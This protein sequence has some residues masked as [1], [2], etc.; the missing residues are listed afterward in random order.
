[1]EQNIDNNEIYSN[2]NIGNIN[3]YKNVPVVA[4]RD[5]VVF[6]GTTVYFEVGREATVKAVNEAMH[7]KQYIFAVAQ[8]DPKVEHPKQNDLFEI[9]T[10]AQ[11]KQL[12]TMP[13]NVVRVIIV[14]QEKMKLGS[15]V[16]EDGYYKADLE[17]VEESRQ[18]SYDIETIALIRGLKDLFSVYVNERGRINK[19][20]VDEIMDCTDLDSL[21]NQ[22]ATGMQVN[23]QFKQKILAE[24][25]IYQRHEDIASKYKTFFL[26]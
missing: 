21:I 23:Y 7:G 25:D 14:G 17:K 6:P 22:I 10:L 9:G 24:T 12:V 19:N 8:K 15:L 4:L 20:V 1:M 5:V 2:N 26:I 3:E 13:G 11:V 16:L 18:I